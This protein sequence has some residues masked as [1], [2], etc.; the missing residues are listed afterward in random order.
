MGGSGS[1]SGR[2]FEIA[3]CS[4]N[5]VITLTY[6]ATSARAIAFYDNGSSSSTTATETITAT[7]VGTLGTA[8]NRC[9]HTVATSGTLYITIE[10][11][12]FGIYSITRTAASGEKY[13]ITGEVSGLE[14]DSTF[15]LTDSSNAEAV[16]TA[17]VS[18]DET[19]STGYIYTAT[20]TAESAPFSTSTKLIVSMDNYSADPET[21]ELSEV[22]GDAYSFVGSDISFEQ[23][24]VTA[25]VSNTAVTFPNNGFLTTDTTA[26]IYAG[27]STTANN[28]TITDGSAKLVDQ[29]SAT[30]NLTI[31][32][33]S[34]ISTLESGSVTFS[35]TV[36]GISNSGSKWSPITFKTSGGDTIAAI[37]SSST[38]DASAD[39]TTPNGNYYSLAIPNGTDSNNSTLYD[40]YE[41]G[42]AQGSSTT[43]F[44]YSITFDYDTDTVT[45]TIDGGTPVETTSLGD[46]TSL[47]AIGQIAAMT[48]GTESREFVLGA[49]NISADVDYIYFGISSEQQSSNI[50]YSITD[51][52]TVYK[53]GTVVYEGVELLDGTEKTIESLE[54]SGDLI[55][56]GDIEA[57]YVVAYIISLS[58]GNSKTDL[59]I[60]FDDGS[61]A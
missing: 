13:T 11:N 6:T 3:N 56:N 1:V 30:T 45:L 28:V 33:T 9:S 12:K 27:T 37:R 38:A 57:E 54:S 17:T 61:E 60:E 53:T 49:I 7:T 26:G 34:G 16:Y 50:S 29:G 18:E 23:T 5:D 51:G 25:S 2:H 48:A 22:S 20:E 36:S 32:L 55:T 44:T 14:A 19:S 58:T 42:T 35:G 40:Y 47:S 39:S 21:I 43:S 41:T 8:V 4:K 10:N 52:T 15:T 31:N 24:I 59:S 46:L